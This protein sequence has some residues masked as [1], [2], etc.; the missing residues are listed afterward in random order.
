M[1]MRYFLAAAL[2]AS[3]GA[4]AQVYK[5]PD[6]AGRTVLQQTPC[7]GGKQLDVRPASGRTAT[8]MPAAGPAPAPVAAV[9]APAPA[10]ST[11]P[12]PGPGAP[13]KSSLEREADMCLAWYLPMLKNP[14]GAY[15]TRPSKDGRVVTITVHATNSY[16]GVVT[17]TARCEIHNGKLD[18]GWTKTHAE[19]LK[20]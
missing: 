19:R 14:R 4:S 11:T 15:Y 16:G 7:A 6:A 2:L 17:E 9:P 10:P 3:G 20:W 8:P 1:R 18:E 13:A 5:C 12:P